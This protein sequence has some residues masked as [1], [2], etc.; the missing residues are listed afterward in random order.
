MDDIINKNFKERCTNCKGIG[1]VKKTKEI[2]CVGCSNNNLKCCYL[3]EN[4]IKS[5]YEE[6]SKCF[7]R[8]Q[9]QM[10]H[11]ITIKKTCNKNEK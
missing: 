5:L 6:C 11:K 10:T 7:G 9:F 2:K 8:G 3:C 4:V 1:L